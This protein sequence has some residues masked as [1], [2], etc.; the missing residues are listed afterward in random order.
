MTWLYPY[1]RAGRVQ[2]YFGQV[3]QSD[4]TYNVSLQQTVSTLILDQFV[5][6]HK[7]V[8]IPV[9][10]NGFTSVP[11]KSLTY[12]LFWLFGNGFN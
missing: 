7:S 10:L 3:L 9:C 12:D 6:T 8:T 5:G 4:M 2:I 1:Y 11:V